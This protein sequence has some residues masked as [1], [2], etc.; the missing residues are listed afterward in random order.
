M[1][2]SPQSPNKGSR[3]AAASST[4]PRK[5]YR[6]KMTDAYAMD[7]L[8][9]EVVSPASGQYFEDDSM[10]LLNEINLLFD[11][12]IQYYFTPTGLTAIQ[13][14]ILIT[15][16]KDGPMTVSQLGKSLEIGSSNITPLCKRLEAMQLVTRTRD[17]YDQRVVFVSI[18]DKA[19]ELLTS[20]NKEIRAKT[21]QEAPVLTADEQ[22]S[23]RH[24]LQLLRSHLASIVQTT[25][26][27]QQSSEINDKRRKRLEAARLATELSES[28]RQEQKKHAA[29]HSQSKMN[30][31]VSEVAD[32]D[33]L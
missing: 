26:K 11:K 13:I 31:I 17:T 23:V 20:V 8:G 3:D 15:L 5:V 27:Q 19:R 25:E 14:P 6:S 28:R 10:H 7:D 30:P 9:E 12:I 18:T 33:D 16:L 2:Y 4:P 21:A 1:A 29:Q 24:G 22:D 32:K